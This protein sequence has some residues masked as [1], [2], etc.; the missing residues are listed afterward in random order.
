MQV[1]NSH[2]SMHNGQWSNSGVYVSVKAFKN[3]LD[4]KNCIFMTLLNVTKKVQKTTLSYISYH[5]IT[6]KCCVYAAGTDGTEQ[7][8]TYL[9]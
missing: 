1:E 2:K 3:H 6:H 8:S 4:I 9:L 5:H 7:T